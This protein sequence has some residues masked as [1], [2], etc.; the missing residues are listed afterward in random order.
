[1]PDGHIEFL[2]RLDNQVK[3][4]GYRI[5]LEEI[6][7]LLSNHPVVRE[8]VVM[9]REDSSGDARLI[10]YIVPAGSTR[11]T[12]SELRDYLREKLP[13]YMTPANFVLLD[14]LPLTLHGKVDRRSLLEIALPAMDEA[15]YIPPANALEEKIAGVWAAIL[16]RER[17]GIDDHFFDLGGHS[18]LAIRAQDHLSRELG[19]EIP[20][21]K[22]FEH[23][24]VRRLAQHL[25]HQ[26]TSQAL[27]DQSTEVWAEKR[28]QALKQ[29]RQTIRS[30]S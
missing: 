13:A 22:L 10:A 16:R 12:V 26:V 25:S 5:E 27:N 20:L 3:I 4:R 21:L 23:P 6:E 29:R 30:L 28:K 1:L 7:A 11:A 2:G 17:I 8:A 14:K 15:E 18:L 24:T 9:A 19:Q